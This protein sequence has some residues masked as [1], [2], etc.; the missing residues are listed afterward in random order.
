M[1][2]RKGFRSRTPPV[3]VGETIKEKVLS[4]G[5]KGDGVLKYKGYVIFVPNVKKD[6]F[7]EVRVTRTFRNVGFAE[8]IRKL[9]DEKAETNEEHIKN[10]EQES[11]EQHIEKYNYEQDSEDF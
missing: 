5:A 6:E 4:V 9:G 1:K 8:L 11:E 7:V 10:I 3:R 2:F